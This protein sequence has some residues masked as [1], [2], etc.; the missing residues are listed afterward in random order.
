MQITFTK[1]SIL[2]FLSLIHFATI[3]FSQ[4]QNNNWLF[5][6]ELGITFNTAP[7]SILNSSVMVQVEGSASISDQNGNLLFFTDGV[8]VWNKNQQQMPN[9]FGLLGNSSSTQSALIVPKPGNC[10]IYYIFTVPSQD[11]LTPLSYSIVDMS[12]DNGLGDITSTKNVALYA[13]VTERLTATLKSNGTDYWVVAQQVGTNGYMAYSITSAGVNTT[14]II[15]YSGF[16]HLNLTG[17]INVLGYMKISSDGSK[18][19]YANLYGPTSAELLDFNNQTG[20]VSNA[21]QLLPLPAYGVE[22]SPDNSKLYLSTEN[23]PFI[24]VQY[25]LAAGSPSAI[26]NSEQDIYN[27]T[28]TINTNPEYGGAMQLGPDN[29]IY[30]DR[31][32]QNFLGIIDQPNLAGSSCNYVDNGITLNGKCQD[33]L[34]NCIKNYAVSPCFSC[35]VINNTAGNII[36]VS[37]CSG[38]NYILP[39]GN[40]IDTAGIYYDTVKSSMNC[41]SII[42]IVHLTIYPTSTTNITDSFYNGEGYRLPSGTVVN[43]PGNYQSILIDINDCDSTINTTLV[44]RT[45]LACTISP[46]TFFTPNG[47]A[48][49]DVWKIFTGGCIKQ[50]NISIY[51]RW[52]GLVYHSENYNND[53]NGEYKNNRL[54]DATY[55]YV[56]NATF[57]DMH[58]Q[59][60]TGNVT[61]VR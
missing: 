6:E 22:F 47:D 21:M 36:S 59:E 1:K 33:G 16:N 10:N 39:S 5:G 53:W 37:I 31:L 52:G 32:Q 20:M 27:S 41:D 58:Q 8:S 3:C 12:L 46:P 48:V 30:V 7:P 23:A 15:S 18:L 42:T 28:P 56:I 51:N 19:C 38:S 26:I 35:P 11:T 29:K 9:G 34:P 44:L 25:N 54:P 49:N 17:D 55:Y 24:I 43:T 61:I 45:S 13:P 4:K 14:P 60:L 57:N 2:L 50:L 40:S